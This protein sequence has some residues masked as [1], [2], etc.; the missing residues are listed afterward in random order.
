MSGKTKA[1]HCRRGFSYVPA[2]NSPRCPVCIAR[3]E[4]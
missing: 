2:T 3:A 4:K 1:K